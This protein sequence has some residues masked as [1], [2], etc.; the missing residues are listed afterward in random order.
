M[1][2]NIL[3]QWT[4]L[5]LCHVIRGGKKRK[6]SNDYL[7]TFCRGRGE[8]VSDHLVIELFQVFSRMKLFK[9]SQILLFKS[10]LC[11]TE[12]LSLFLTT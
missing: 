11:A 12:I 1:A 7:S 3:A 2:P 8:C 10:C 5:L 6:D 4:L 9:A